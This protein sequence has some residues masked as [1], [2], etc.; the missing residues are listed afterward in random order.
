MEFLGATGARIENG[1]VAD[2]GDL[3]AELVAAR[4]A[5]VACPLAHLALIECSGD[6][7]R[8]FL[9]NQLTTDI[10][11]LTAE[12]AQNTA[13]CTAKGRMFASFILYREA[14]AYRALVSSDLAAAVQKRLQMYVLRSK[15]AIADVSE[16]NRAIGLSGEH[17]EALLRD[18]GLPIPVK[19]LEVGAFAE[20]KVIRLDPLRFIVVAASAAAQGLWSAFA[21]KARAVGTPAWNWLDIDAG[22]TLVTRATSEEF[23]PQMANFDQIGA[24]SFHKGCYPGQEVVARAQYLGRI[25]RHLYRLQ[26]SAPVAAGTTIVAPDNAEHPWGIVASAAPAPGGGYDALAVIQESYAEA[27]SLHFG[28]PDG[29]AIAPDAIT[30]V[31]I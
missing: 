23:V 12:V 24:V 6:D 9:H 29:P 7:A 1:V 16:A 17:A 22:I 28:H 2:F 4:E 19:R 14:K 27:A 26:T 15:V 25:K 13:W 18:A 20:G 8:E 31:E 11:H 5:T 10:N 3:S 30:R 21:A